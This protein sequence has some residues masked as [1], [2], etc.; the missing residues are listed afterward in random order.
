MM[1]LRV[2][3]EE[4]DSEM[5]VVTLYKTPKFGKYEKGQSA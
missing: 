1:L 2:L 4:T 5:A 3:I